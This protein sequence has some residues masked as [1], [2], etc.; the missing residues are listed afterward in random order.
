MQSIFF[1]Y[2]F[3]LSLALLRIF[4]FY[5]LS[6]VPGIVLLCRALEIKNKIKQNVKINETLSSYQD[7]LQNNELV[8]LT[9]FRTV[10]G[11]ML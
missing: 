7:Q 8:E 10:L 2:E 4:I 3:I 9:R 1:F 11:A 5:F 6:Q